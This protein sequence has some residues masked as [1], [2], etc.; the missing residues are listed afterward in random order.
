MPVI[1]NRGHDAIDIFVR[2]QFFIMASHGKIHIHNLARQRVA[3]IVEVGGGGAFHSG[4]SNGRT[5][6]RRALHA[7]AYHSEPHP[8]AC[9]HRALSC[10]YR[11]GIQHEAFCRDRYASSRRPKFQKFTA[12]KFVLH[13]IPRLDLFY[14]CS[15]FIATSL[16]NTTSLSL[17][18]CRPM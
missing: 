7:N 8:V 6:Q 11:L 13:G 1:G 4:Q 18:F 5:Q 12:R 3:A 15:L 16:K 10:K 2:Q 17:W 14:F 9:G